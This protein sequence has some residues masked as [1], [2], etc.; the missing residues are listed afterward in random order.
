LK[1][2]GGGRGGEEER[3]RRGENDKWRWIEAIPPRE[4]PTAILLRLKIIPK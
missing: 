3:R 1:G 2:G 4:L